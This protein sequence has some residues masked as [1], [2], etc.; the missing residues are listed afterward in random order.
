MMSMELNNLLSVLN[1]R[2][3]FPTV[4]EHKCCPEI[5]STFKFENW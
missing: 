1:K 3:M 4:L 5:S 2:G